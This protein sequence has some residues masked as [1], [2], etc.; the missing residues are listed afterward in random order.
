MR[1]KNRFTLVELLVVISIIALLVSI[2]LPALN[3]AREITKFTVCAANMHQVG[4]AM[5]MYGEDNIHRA[6]PGDNSS[7]NNIYA[8]SINT[9]QWQPVDMGHLLVTRQS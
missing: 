2:L 8:P 7:G 4:L 9:D 5:L 6:V 1:Q 3:K